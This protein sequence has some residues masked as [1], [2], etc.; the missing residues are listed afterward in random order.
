MPRRL[1][2]LFAFCL[3]AFAQ[4][5]CTAN[6][7]VPA[8][9]RAE[10]I[11]EQVSDLVV[12]CTGGNPATTLSVTW[13]L[14]LNTNITSRV[15]TGEGTEA[16]MIVDNPTAPGG[17]TTNAV[18]ASANSLR[19]SG[20][21]LV[22]PGAGTRVIRFTNLRANASGLG[23][24]STAVPTQVVSFISS[25]SAGA[26]TINNPQ[27]ILAHVQEGMTFST[28]TGADP[29]SALGEKGFR[30]QAGAGTSSAPA[31]YL[32]FTEGFATA[33]R[34]RGSG[35]QTTPGT[36]YNTESG[37][38]VTL[39]GI[40]N[41]GLA[42]SG[43][44]LAAA[45][46]NIPRNVR[47]WVGVSDRTGRAD[48]AEVV[49]GSAAMIGGIRVTEVH[50]SGGAGTA[51][52]EVKTADPV[53]RENFDFP[54]FFGVTGEIGS[55]VGTVSGSLVPISTVTTGSTTA[56]IP[57]FAQNGTSRPLV[58]SAFT[59]TCTPAAGPRSTGVAYSTTCTTINGVGNILWSI[60]AGALPAGLALS[61]TT[62]A[63]VRI[64]GTPTGSGAYDFTLSARDV[65]MPPQT[66]TERFTGTLTAAVR[67][68]CAPGAP[69]SA[70]GVAYLETCAAAGGVPPYR[71][72]ITQG[73]L[74]AGLSLSA[75]TGTVTSISGTPTAPGAFRYNLTLS[76]S[77]VP[78]QTDNETYEGAV[79]DRLTLSCTPTTGPT[80]AGVAFTTTCT[81]SR[82]TAPYVFATTGTL[83]AGLSAAATATTYTISG[84]PTAT[85]AYTFGVSVSDSTA[86]AQT[87]TQSFTGTLAAAMSVTCS[88]AAGPST[89]GVAYTTTCTA[90][91]GAAP[92][93]WSIGAGALPPGLTLSGGTAAATTIAGTPSGTGSYSFTVTA[94]DSS[95][96]ARTAT[97]E[98]SG[99]L[100]TQP[101]RTFSAAS[102]RE[103]AIAPDSI[104]SLFGSGLAPRTE[105]AVGPAVTTLGGVSVRVTDSRGAARDAQ[106]F[107]ASDG[108]INFLTPAA[109]APGTA[110]IAVVRQG[111]ATST[112]STEVAS[113]PPGIFVVSGGSTGPAAFYLRVTASGQ[114]SQ[115]Y[116]FDP[117]TLS[118]VSIPRSDGDGIYLLLYGTGFRNHAGAVTATANGQTVPV[119]GALAQ[120][121]F[122]GLDQ[123]NIG[124]LPAGLPSGFVTIRVAFDG[125]AANDITVRLQ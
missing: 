88:P 80:A 33:F 12:Q 114:R 83:P 103:G 86:P 5:T 3:P 65:D 38:T 35:N 72:T 42:D 41:A 11:T 91:G 37:Y 94:Q 17:S 98:F 13:T 22:P 40:G 34:P 26:I 44:K 110:T 64:S 52:W 45:F 124:P 82:G 47:V 7:G 116:T 27:Q 89:T 24:S 81:A 112:G 120:G 113:I 43:T 76:D 97:Q 46:Q 115:D 20:V 90:A 53:R 4:V 123:V 96:P 19:W 101:F 78:P 49:N 23:A 84:T 117:A 60:S 9:V 61:A 122:A 121:Q 75:T 99:T 1:V 29:N 79:A 100:G 85:G 30:M 15:F 125:V 59:I 74:P 106:L 111:G 73:S 87:A 48:Y 119:L 51:S 102:F 54:V 118:A 93:R 68:T 56:A 69:P 66:D 50:L 62:G 63:T 21:P 109:T 16:L 71:W 105:S 28:Q 58:S 104:A 18:R 77:S 70:V 14:F 2:L 8:L 6:G 55:G 95:T 67:M 108:Q 10:G 39:S 36:V 57:R 92:F 25:T 31:A 32:R 107:F